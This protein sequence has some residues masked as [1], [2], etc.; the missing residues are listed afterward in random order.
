MNETSTRSG[1]P[2]G[3]ILLV[4]LAGFVIALAGLKQISGIVAPAFFA[5][6]LVLTGRPLHKWMV[7]KKVPRLLSATLV[8]MLLY[9]LLLLIVGGLGF[10]IA[11]LTLELPKYGD[12]FNQMWESLL[13]LVERFGINPDKTLHDAINSFDVSRIAGLA[14]SLLSSLSNVGSQ[15]LMLLIILFFLTIDT[16]DVRG[17][18]STLIASRPHLAEALSAFSLSVRKY[19]FVTTI[20]GLIVALLDVVALGII[21]VPLA[22]T[23]GIL[24]FVTNYIPNI[25][26]VLGLIPPALMALL[27]LGPIEALAVVIA[28]AVINFVLQTIIQPK[29]TGDA[30]GLNTTA[31]FLSLALWATVLGPFGAL[32]AVPLTSFFKAILVDA[33]PESRWMNAFLTNEKPND[34]TTKKGP[35]SVPGVMSLTTAEVGRLPRTESGATVVFP[36]RPDPQASRPFASDDE[37]EVAPKTE[38]TEPEIVADEQRTDKEL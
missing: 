24:S 18:V 36:E 15:I 10:G 31:T 7:S 5:L 8:M 12:T 33:D 30:V 35:E 17:R 38:E 29:F 2:R 19:W 16:Q 26:F 4:A 28:Y 11:Q 22:W 6:T 25:G 34:S 14:N 27:V 20:F 32:L 23:W 13:N 9:L 37:D 1:A 21:G 3:L